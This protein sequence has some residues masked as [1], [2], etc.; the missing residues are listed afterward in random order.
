MEE[1]DCLYEYTNGGYWIGS[2]RCFKYHVGTP[3]SK[4]NCLIISAIGLPPKI[5]ANVWNSQELFNVSSC[6]FLASSALPNNPICCITEYGLYKR[7]VPKW[8]V[9]CF[10]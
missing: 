6:A 1:F 3:A 8:L 10:E 4:H 2:I 9:S 5:L 7:N